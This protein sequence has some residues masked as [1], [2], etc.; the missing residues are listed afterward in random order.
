MKTRGDNPLHIMVIAASSERRASLLAMAENAVQARITTSH[1]ISLERIFQVAAE[2]IVVDVD[3]PELSS[4]LIRLAQALPGGTG[5]V[6]LADNPDPSW[7]ILALRSGI[8]AILSREVSGEELRLAILAAES[9][10]VLLH[11][12]SAQNLGSQSFTQNHDAVIPAESLTV[13]EKEVLSLVREG[14][15][16]KE[17]AGRLHISEHTVKFHISSILGKLGAA[18]RTEAV[19]QGIRRGFITI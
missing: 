17:I 10:L 18:S 19:S 9:G 3:G 12:T 5:L 14:L 1:G 7:V 15:G 11:P 13:R 16:N 6:A 4:A 8:N 2:T